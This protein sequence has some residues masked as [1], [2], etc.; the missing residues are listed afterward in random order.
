MD[1][2][3]ADREKEIERVKK[4]RLICGKNWSYSRSEMNIIKQHNL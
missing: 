3:W 2:Y 4:L 1:K